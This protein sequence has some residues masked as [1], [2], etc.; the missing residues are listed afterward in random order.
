MDVS[1]ILLTFNSQDTI[2][3]GLDCI[4]LSILSSK[5]NCEL[6]VI[7][8]NS[9]DNT[10]NIIK[11]KGLRYEL[12]NIDYQNRSISFNLGAKK[13]KGKYLRRVDSR[14]LIPNNSIHECHSFLNNNFPAT[15]ETFSS[16][17][18]IALLILGIDK[19]VYSETPLMFIHFSR[20][21]LVIVFSIL[22]S[23]SNI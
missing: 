3:E 17:L 13:A 16:P 12:V 5:L 23:F 2:S 14:S 18:V 9:T 6:L 15:L 7:D 21:E 4:N 19:E 20:W 1:I 22:S 11:E 10:I 8:A